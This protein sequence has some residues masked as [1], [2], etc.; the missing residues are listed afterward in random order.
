M[1]QETTR[2]GFV[3]AAAAAGIGI[4]LP[5]ARAAAVPRP[6]ILG[7]KRVR[8]KPFPTWP[9]FGEPEKKALLEVLESGHW[10][11]GSG[12]KVDQFE[13][14]Y[15]KL[16]GA[17][18]CVAVANG[19]S[20][21]LASLGALGVG[22]GDEVIVPPYTFVATV[23][24]VLALNA[25]PRFVD[26]DRESFQIDAR[27][28]EAAITERTK[29]IIPVHLG[30][31]AAD[32]DAVL[33]IARKHKLAVVEDACQAHLGEWRGRKVGTWGTSGAFS[34]QASKNLN[35]GEGG[36]ILTADGELAEK[37]YAFHNN[38]RARKTNSY[39]FSY[40]PTRGI[41]LRMT[42]F[43][44]AL[45]LAQ[46]ARLQEQS[47]TRWENGQY[48]TGMLR[49]IPGITPA[50][51]YEGCTRNAFHLYMFRYDPEKFAGMPRAK[52]M[53]ALEK[54]GIPCSSG[55]TP[56]NKQSFITETI[57]SRSYQKLYPKRLLAAWEEQNACPENDRLCEE[58]VWF[59]QNM[60]LG[61]R[62][63]MDQIAEAI[64]KIQA[65]AGDVA[66]L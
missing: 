41:N 43:Q 15:K 31:N 37:C 53:V 55:Y 13:E 51:M 10:F 44:G 60:L 19:T 30:G 11:R 35:S 27:K 56:L 63:D 46:M 29:A 47:N 9:V 21:L 25:L 18:H 64:G 3:A 7:G 54:E 50:R 6:A 48:L 5:S 32:L 24:V 26:S 49:E 62:S 42:E 61:P 20:A 59:T 22:P 36:A 23:N 2:R 14:G 1:S 28:I 45:L 40:L 58:A 39:N 66:K 4:T 65:H 34:F 16:T 52:F 33:A 8:T 17:K 57:H 12:E 38:C